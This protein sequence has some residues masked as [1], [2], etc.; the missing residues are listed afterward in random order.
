MVKF[1]EILESPVLL[2]IFN[3]PDTTA[4]VFQEI[5]KA[6][7]R[8]LYI[9]ADGPR[10][11]K[12]GELARCE[13]ARA[14]AAD[15]DWPCQVTTLFQQENLGC[16]L[17]VS[18]AITWFFKHEE[19]GIILEDDIVPAPAFFQYCDEL[20]NLYRDNESI[21]MISGSNLTGGASF[22]PES[23]FFTRY[24]HIW[25][26]ATWRRA[27]AKYDVAMSDWPHWRGG[28]GLRRFF[29]NDS[30]VE[31]FWREIFDAVWS[32]RI[33]T[34][35]YQW[36]FC[37]WKNNALAICPSWN[38]T[39]NIGFSSDAT[40][41]T[42]GTPSYVINSPVKNLD[43]PLS[44]PHRATRNL[45]AD[46]HQE[47][48]IYNIAK[49]SSMKKGYFEM[50]LDLVESL[51]RT[52]TGKVS[53]KWASYLT[54]Y[55][56]IFN[57]LR[58]ESI[59]MLE[60]GVQNGGSLETWSA[61][62]KNAK[63]IVGCDIDSKCASLSFDDPRISVV[64]G[65]ACKIETVQKIVSIVPS[66]DLVIDDGSHISTDIINAFLAYFPLLRPGG[67]YIV[68]DAHCLYMNDFGGGVLNNFGGYAFFKSL[69]DVISYQFWN[70][71]IS[72]GALMRTFFDLNSTP[73]FITDGWIES[74]EFRNSI[75]SI[76]KSLQPGHNKIGERVVV[77][78][79]ADVQQWGNK[80]PK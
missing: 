18:S 14:I 62:F 13:E 44:H 6:R 28:D 58:N 34:W 75:I 52:K 63:S 22:S 55:D 16:K 1:E 73:S 57:E 20:L 49:A 41:T 24:I 60:I 79:I 4:L 51:H 12:A 54:Y 40:H 19:E 9:A 80:F 7:P 8:K 46:F 67:I 72:I 38:L 66:F 43:F 3:R 48:Y 53:D 23:Y 35:D 56:S 30:A 29:D 76:K 71:Q 77:G 74:I 2:I 5:R 21:M 64:I 15:V 70:D 50:G 26:W 10:L 27:W 65:D 17:G 42:A 11:G 68:E 32:N 47:S 78:D 33:D 31:H 45:A 59:S 39:K 61:Y 25:G 69:V 37:C 36:V